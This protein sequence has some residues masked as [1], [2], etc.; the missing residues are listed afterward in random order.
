VRSPFERA[1]GVPWEAFLIRAAWQTEMSLGWNELVSLYFCSSSYAEAL[2]VDFARE[3]DERH[4]F[5]GGY[6]EF[7]IGN[8][9]F[10]RCC[11]VVRVMLV[12][13]GVLMSPHSVVTM[14]E[15]VGS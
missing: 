5:G 3:I 7:A 14:R 1:C 11:W 2:G 9:L 15:N 10:V 8:N 6:S 13:E 4:L 12:I